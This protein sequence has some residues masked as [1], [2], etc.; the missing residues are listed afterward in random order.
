[1]QLDRIGFSFDWD[2]NT[3]II[4]IINGHDWI[5]KQL[6]DSYYCRSLDKAE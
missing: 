5:F 4:A 3:D 2:E 1:M 6:F